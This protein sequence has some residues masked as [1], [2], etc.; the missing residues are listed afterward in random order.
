MDTIRP[1]KDK[2]MT[3]NY[4]SLLYSSIR[5]IVVFFWDSKDCLLLVT[6]HT[7]L[8]TEDQSHVLLVRYTALG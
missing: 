3:L 2:K 7:Q 4:N 8:E 5:N 1:R 6:R